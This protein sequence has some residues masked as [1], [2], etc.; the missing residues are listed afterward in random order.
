M[1]SSG[2]LRSWNEERGFG[3]IAP[4]QGGAELFVHVSAF[5]RD[6]SR[7]V[8]GETVSFEQGRGKDGKPQAVNV[9]RTAVGQVQP[10]SRESL[11]VRSRPRWHAWLALCLIVAIGVWS[12]GRYQAGAHR[13]HLENMPPTAAPVQEPVAASAP[14]SFRCDGR[15]Q[16]SQMT[17]CAEATW[18]IGHCPGT[19]MDGNH[20]GVP[21]EQQ[22]CTSPG[23]R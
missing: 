18:F 19:K 10:L 15:T 3:F 7:P 14:V 1:R 9:I 8:V 5:P 12:Y 6:G 16:C 4:M 2:I 20:D 23:A 22:W 11:R 17:S 21:C 13:R